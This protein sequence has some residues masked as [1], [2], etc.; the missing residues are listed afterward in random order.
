[1]DGFVLRRGLTEPQRRAAL[2]F[3]EYMED[4]ATYRWLIMGEDITENRVPR[5][6]ISRH[7][8]SFSSRTD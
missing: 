5:Y 8:Y 1:M 6:L 3:V 2:R 4:P 7:E